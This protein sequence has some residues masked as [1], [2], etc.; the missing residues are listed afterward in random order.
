MKKGALVLSSALLLVAFVWSCQQQESAPLSPV[1][2]EG[3]IAAKKG[4]GAG[5]GEKKPKATFDVQVYFDDELVATR[6][7]AVASRGETHLPGQGGD[8]ITLTLSEGVG[9]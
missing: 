8:P 7:G 4:G 6:L 5:G 1:S 2:P 9:C 3:S